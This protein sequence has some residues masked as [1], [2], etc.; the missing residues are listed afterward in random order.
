MV[1]V[2]PTP[3]D[4]R[5]LIDAAEQS[6]RP[7]Y[8]SAI[9]VAATTGIRRAELCAIRR[10]RDIDWERGL[11][12]VTASIVVLKDVPLQE[13]PTKNRGGRTI[14]RGDL[15]A[16]DGLLGVTG[17]DAGRTRSSVA[18]RHYSGRVEETDRDLANAVASLLA[19]EGGTR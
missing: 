11:L 9:L 16:G 12:T 7:E 14:A 13:I 17:C 15:R 4:V 6:K 3:G 10:R 2:V 18:A 5:R 19:P 8:A 1:P